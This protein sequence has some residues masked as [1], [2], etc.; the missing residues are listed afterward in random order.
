MQQPRHHKPKFMNT[1]HHLGHLTLALIVGSL[2]L[3]LT[4]QAEQQQKK[5]HPPYQLIDL[6]TFGGPSST[7]EDLS[8][9]LN[10]QGTAIGAADTPK[11]ETLG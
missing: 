5:E 2:A 3:P 6:G 7:F 10:N 1:K 11:V 9:T 4:T 8:K